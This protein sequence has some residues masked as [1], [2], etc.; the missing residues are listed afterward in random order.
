M[1]GYTSDKNIAD[2]LAN[3]YQQRFSCTPTSH[4]EYTA[5]R[6]NLLQNGSPR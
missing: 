6:R 4:Q 3:E 2:H 5:F 1:D